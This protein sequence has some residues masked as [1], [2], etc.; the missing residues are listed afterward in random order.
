M[1]TKILELSIK[2]LFLKKRG[3]KKEEED[4]NL[5]NFNLS[6]PREGTP[7]ATN[8]KKI[9]AKEPIP[10]YD[11]LPYSQKVIFKEEIR[12]GTELGITVEYIDNPSTYEK[13]AVEV[14]K[15]IFK[16]ALGVAT[17]GIG[18]MVLSS[19]TSKMGGALIENMKAVKS[20]LTIGSGSQTI[21]ISKLDDEG[22]IR[23]PLKVKKR[24]M[25]KIKKTELDYTTML[26]K[27][28]EE[29]VLGIPKGENGFII[30]KYK[31]LG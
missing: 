7:F 13:I 9:M 19:A 29:E 8:F 4:I 17:G 10:N 21:D 20:I 11:E 27:D 24:I 15:G 1:N 22:E 14:F 16:T 23:I 6:F 2:S 31:V 26:Y 3:V 5:I 18:N 28:I 25:K 30:L 12:G